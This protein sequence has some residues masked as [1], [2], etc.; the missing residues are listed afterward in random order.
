MFF[1]AVRTE[2]ALES[3]GRSRDRAIAWSCALLLFLGLAGGVAGAPDSAKHVIVVPLEGVV[4]LGMA[5][6]VER[7]ITEAI[8]TGADAVLLD[9]NTLGGRV[10]AALLI[11]DALIGSPVRTI[12]FVHPRAISAGALISLACEK[13]VMEPGGSIGAATPVVGGA[14][15]KMEA[16]DEKMVSYFRTEMRAT[17]ERNGR[18]GDLVEAMVDREI[19]IE[20]ITAK[21]KLLTLT[22]ADALRFGVADFEAHSIDE[23]LKLLDLEGAVQITHQLNWAERFA[24]IVSNPVLS[25]FLMSVGFLGIMLEFYRPGWGISGTLGVI[26]LLLFFLGHYVVRLAGWEEVLLFALGL[27][28]LTLEF[29]VIPGFGVAGIAGIA[30]MLLSVFLALIGRDLRVSWHLGYVTDALTVVA[31]GVLGIAVGGVL[32]V[33]FLPTTRAGSFFIL[34]RSLE[35]DDGYVTHA[36]SLEDKF[37]SGTVGRAV[38]D[39]R[40][41]GIIRVGG[42]RIDA[43][44]DGSYVQ[45]G[46]EVSIVG[47]RAGQ[48]VVRPTESEDPDGGGES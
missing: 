39:L 16:A 7:A 45:H 32:I 38:G 6:F 9:I 40:P 29:F 18:R 48:P 10:D 24:R 5:P 20:G 46:T 31:G 21:G 1:Q 3:R 34:R 42:T 44:S 28:L 22:T 2:L 43:V 27:L 4:D 14:G 12:A 8:D 33:R 23:V 25:S 35:S 11:R 36:R 30:A 26:C 37:P 15:E 17:A 19:E 41:A 47:W 13:I